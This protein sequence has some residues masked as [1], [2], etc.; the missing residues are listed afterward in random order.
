MTTIDLLRD[1]PPIVA[2][3]DKHQPEPVL[4]PI[5]ALVQQQATEIAELAKV[6]LRAVALAQFG[7]WRGAVAAARKTLAGVVHDVS[8][9]SK[10]AEVKSLR[11]RLI[12]EPRAE[13]R[14]VSKAVKSRLAAVSK[15][16]GA[17]EEEAVKA[18][19]EVETLITPQIEAGDAALEAARQ[20]AARL[21]AE[22][23]QKIDDE[24]ATITGF[25]ERAKDTEGMTAERV[26]TGIGKLEALTFSA[27]DWTDPVAAAKVQ[28]QTI[29][30]MRQLHAKLAAEEAAAAQMAALREANERMAKMLADQQAALDAQAAALRAEQDRI[31]GLRA[32]IDEIHAAAT[33]HENATAADLYEAMVA[34]TALDVS[35]AQYQEFTPLAEAAQDATLAKLQDLHFRAVEREESEAAQRASTPAAIVATAAATEGMAENPEPGT[36]EAAQE[37]TEGQD[38]QQVLKA[39]PATADAT[40]RSV[41]ADASPRVGAMGAGQAADA[42]PAAIYSHVPGPAPVFDGAGAEYGVIA[43]DAKPFAASPFYDTPAPAATDPRDEFVALVM[44]AFDCKFPSHPKPSQA[45][46]AEVRAAGLELQRQGL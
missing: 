21:A 2:P 30:G 6:D 14:K 26:A 19:D 18:W 17:A 5:A 42:A 7:D 16:V 10:L 9:A 8:T 15:D 28:V 41:P 29:E 12:N 4:T 46:W 36:L 39:E 24:L 22:R 20:A 38:D 13:V 3:E 43:V 11:Q 45:W 25:L 40:D 37:S 32:R 44:T 33:G 31:A 35:E 34:V 1:L 23:Q 27:E